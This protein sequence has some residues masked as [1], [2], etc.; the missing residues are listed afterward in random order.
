MNVWALLFLKNMANRITW[1]SKKKDAKL[2]D[3]VDSYIFD[4]SVEVIEK[5][6]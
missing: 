3:I 5:I 1:K 4:A 2:D 6:K